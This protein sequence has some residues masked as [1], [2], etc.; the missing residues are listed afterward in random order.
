M[1]IIQYSSLIKLLQYTYL[2]LEVGG[3]SRTL[4]FSLIMQQSPIEVFHKWSRIL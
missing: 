4:E 2:A 1:E 3:V